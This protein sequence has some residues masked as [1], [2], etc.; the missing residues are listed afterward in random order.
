VNTNEVEMGKVLTGLIVAV[1][2][3]VGVEFFT[4]GPS[5]AFDGAFAGFFEAETVEV[6][7]P[8]TVQRA[9]DSVSRSLAE[10]EARR[11]GVLGE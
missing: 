3:W 9:G 4:Q 6:L 5:R 2:I 10:A 8:A 11:K 7:T 1:G